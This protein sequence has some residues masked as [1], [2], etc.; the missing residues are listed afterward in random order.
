M[1]EQA[2]DTMSYFDRLSG[3][4]EEKYSPAGSMQ[5]RIE[6][7][8]AVLKQRV[9]PPAA[10]L[11]FGC[12]AGDIAM[13]CAASGYRVWGLDQSRGMVERARARDF[14]RRIQLDVPLQL[15]PLQTSYE[16]ACFDAILASS[17]LEYLEEPACCLRELRR[18]GRPG[19]W[20]LA[21]VPNIGH[22]TRKVENVLKPL[23]SFVRPVAGARGR[24]WFDYLALSRQRHSY[25]EWSGLFL[26]CGWKCESVQGREE[27]LLLLAARAI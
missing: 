6:R 26:E 27:P 15:H 21:T 16:D 17:V 22:R 10:V 11:D 19:A 13:G 25:A 7:F 18:V 3:R 1:P 5:P 14:D 9:P 12:G 23:G 4:W 8:L 24:D 20:L 2:P